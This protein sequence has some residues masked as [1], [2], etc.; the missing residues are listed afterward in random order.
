MVFTKQG[1]TIVIKYPLSDDTW[2]VEEIKAIQGVIDSRQFTMGPKTKEYEQTFAEYFGA[3]YAVMVNSGSS[4]NLIAI[5]ALFYS[6]KLQRGDEVIVPAVSWSTTYYPIYQYG[7]KLKFV[8][9]D[10][11]TL[12]LD[13]VKVTKAITKSTKAVFAVNLLGNPI[14]YEIL[15]NICKDNNL[16][17]IEDNCEALGAKYNNKYTGT[18]GE[19]GTF[20]T[21]YSH[22]ICTMEGGVAITDD[23]E[24]FHYMLSIR[25]HGWT[26]NLPGESKLYQKS[27]DDF[28]ES[29]NFILPGYNL[30]PLEFEAAIGLKQIDKIGKVIKMRRRNAEYFSELFSESNNVSIQKEI[31]LGSWFGFALILKNQLAGKR[32]MVIDKLLKNNIEVRPIVAGNFTRNPVIKY[33]DHEIHGNLVNANYIHENGFFVG[34]HSTEIS[35]EIEYLFNVLN[36]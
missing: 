28:Y 4:A 6:G 7:L 32:D 35:S 1:I 14:D 12:N 3:K 23:E 22:H 30:R 16:L 5:A 20:S 29:F 26:R 27:N 10:K 18:F 33:M 31:G 2:D 24:L 13:L 34:N 15:L 19:I 25:S 21:F 9:I 11:D 17:L 8:D 36:K